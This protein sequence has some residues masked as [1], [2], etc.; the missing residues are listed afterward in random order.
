MLLGAVTIMFTMRSNLS[1]AILA[2]VESTANVANGTLTTSQLPN[3]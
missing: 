3:V 1:I 2:M